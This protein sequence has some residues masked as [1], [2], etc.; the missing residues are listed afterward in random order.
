MPILGF[1]ETAAMESVS[2]SLTTINLFEVY[3]PLLIYVGAMVLYSVIVWHFYRFLSKRS[4][5]EVNL[6]KYNYSK[7]PVLTK[8]FHYIFFSLKFVF[9]FPVL[10]FVWFSALSGL[11]FFLSSQPIENILLTSITL[12]AAIRATAYYSEDL[13]KDLAKMLPFA[14]LGVFIINPTFFSVEEILV[15]I[16]QLPSF[17]P[18]L[19]AYLVFTVILEVA[20]KLLRFVFIHLSPKHTV[21]EEGS[22]EETMRDI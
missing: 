16:Y 18:L 15:K 2:N 7:N 17:L 19:L 4:L 21:I 6:D 14:L 20:L 11:L 13:S 5:M 10:T 12:V 22:D 9:V 1:N 3:V 8:V